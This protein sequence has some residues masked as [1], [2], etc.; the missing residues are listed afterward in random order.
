MLDALQNAPSGAPRSRV[1]WVLAV[2]VISAF[3]TLQLLNLQLLFSHY[4]RPINPCSKSFIMLESPRDTA[5]CNALS[6]SDI[7]ASTLTLKE[8]AN[9]GSICSERGAVYEP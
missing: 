8:N 7:V 4:H 9:C 5:S 3:S 6:P 1:K 2:R